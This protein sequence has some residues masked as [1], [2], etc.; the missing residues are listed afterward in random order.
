MATGH[1]TVD[2][3]HWTGVSPPEKWTHGR[4]SHPSII[5]SQGCFDRCQFG[6][7]IISRPSD[8]YLRISIRIRI[9]VSVNVIRICICICPRVCVGF[10]FIVLMNTRVQSSVSSFR[11]FQGLFQR[12]WPDI[13]ISPSRRVDMKQFEA[14]NGFA[15]HE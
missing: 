3:G 1:W 4:G 9:C 11:L 2:G 8:P 14:R 15:R 12:G 13:Y 5:T 6:E 7:I 10:L